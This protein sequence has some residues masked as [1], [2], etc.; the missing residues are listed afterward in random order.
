MTKKILKIFPRVAWVAAIL[1][2]AL[3]IQPA[4][5]DGGI[6]PGP[7]HYSKETR[8]SAI[9]YFQNNTENLVLETTFQGNSN[10][11]AWVIPTP[12]Q[13]Q[14]FKS[15]SLLFADLENIT[16]AGHT[17]PD[18]VYNNSFSLLPSGASK[19]AVEVV[20]KK[21]VDIYDTAVLKATDAGAL[22][23]WLADNNYTFP[24][25][26]SSALQSYVDNGWYF[27]VAKIQNTL[28]DD[29]AIQAEMADGTITPL[30]IEFATDKIIYP[31]KLTQM[32]VNYA[33]KNS[34]PVILPPIDSPSESNAPVPPPPAAHMDIILYVISDSK[35]AQDLFTLNW[36]DWLDQKDIDKLNSDNGENWITGQKLF[37]TELD[38]NL[39]L[40]AIDGDLTISSAPD[41]SIFPIPAY[42]TSN[43]WLINLLVFVLVFT[44][45]LLFPPSLLFIILVLLQIFVIQKRWVYFLALAYE[46]LVSLILAIGLLIVLIIA[47]EDPYNYPG[48]ALALLMLFIVS[49][50]L[51]YKMIKRYKNKISN[52]V[53]IEQ[54]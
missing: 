48:L 5:A 7:D 51:T 29:S 44:I 12:S 49:I 18:V 32:S 21:T 20:A 43:F 11:F 22:A 13:P 42:T 41:N 28:A 53:V 50:F 33:Q 52:P 9:I 27:T 3:G 17:G 10:D 23:K 2:L 45:G 14:V 8:Q 16:A 47:Q 34:P 19:S 35:T 4:K 26:Q 40:S 15:N 36:A 24:A 30:R 54:N 46:L 31:M 38:A 39:D 37:L 6:F 25:D 1:S